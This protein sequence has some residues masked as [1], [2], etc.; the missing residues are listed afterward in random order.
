MPVKLS[1]E[2]KEAVL[3]LP[4]KEKDKLLLRLV[5]KDKLLVKRMEF[6]LLEDSTTTDERARNIQA[7]IEK[8]LTA[9]A[10]S[11]Q[12]P[13]Y[14]LMEFR[15]S[16][17]IITEH[18]KV[19]KDKYGEVWL[20]IYMLKTGLELN[21]KTL[22]KFSRNRFDTLGPY[23]ARRIQQILVKIPKLHED[24]Y[25]EIQREMNTLLDLVYSY[26]YLAEAAV[27]IGLPKK[28]HY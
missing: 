5:G 4:A 12:T 9:G 20:T 17:P 21:Y 7:A 3:R 2:L 22:Q 18:V 15:Y 24:Y 23:V 28:W 11:G 25:F 13:G 8:S 26:P 14:L 10:G 1:A 27:A 6:E 19:T 16:N